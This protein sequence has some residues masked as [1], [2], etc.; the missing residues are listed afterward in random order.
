MDAVDFCYVTVH[1][2]PDEDNCVNC[3]INQLH[4]PRSPWTAE[5]KS[6]FTSDVSKTERQNQKTLTEPQCVS[7]FKKLLF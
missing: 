3:S 5:M 6:T 7:V 1:C 4:R 2:A